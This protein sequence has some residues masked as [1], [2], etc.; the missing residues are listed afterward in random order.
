MSVHRVMSGSPKGPFPLG[1]FG[2]I[3]AKSVPTALWVWH[4]DWATGQPLSDNWHCQATGQPP[5]Y[6][7]HV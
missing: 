6:I 1:D 4:V 5:P 3:G 7:K 2:V